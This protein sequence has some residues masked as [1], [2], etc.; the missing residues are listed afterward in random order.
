VQTAKARGL[1]LAI[2]A[3]KPK[4]KQNRKKKGN[5]KEEKMVEINPQ[6]LEPASPPISRTRSLTSW[7][8]QA[9]V[10]RMQTQMYISWHKWWKKS[11]GP[12][13]SIRRPWFDQRFLISAV[14]SGSKRQI[15]RVYGNSV[16]SHIR[17]H[18]EYIYSKPS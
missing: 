16:S 9:Y 4:S 3:L 5:R 17:N 15:A 8:A 1:R 7:A 2:L 18:S 11:T 10:T 6:G 13:D 12:Y 14:G